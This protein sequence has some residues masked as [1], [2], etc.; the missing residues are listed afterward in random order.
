MH[1]THVH[2]IYDVK[3][4]LCCLVVVHNFSFGFYASLCFFMVRRVQVH[5][6]CFMKSAIVLLILGNWCDVKGC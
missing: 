5:E 3:F 4:G 1:Y 2:F 6:H